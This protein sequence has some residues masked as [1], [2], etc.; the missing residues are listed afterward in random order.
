[1][2]VPSTGWMQHPSR[3]IGVDNSTIASCRVDAAR[4]ANERPRPAA[5]A[6]A[7]D[8]AEVNR[9]ARRSGELLIFGARV[10]DDALRCP[11]RRRRRHP[12]WYLMLVRDR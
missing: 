4:V 3:T 10:I 11:S 6:T 7:R 8:F 12:A 1:M 2:S 5:R 9:G